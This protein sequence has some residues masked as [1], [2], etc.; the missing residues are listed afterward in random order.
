MPFTLSHAAAALPFRRF[1]PVWPALV[2]GTM[3]P[4]FEYFL[5]LSDEGRTGHHFPGLVIITLP[6]AILVFC[7][8][9]CYVRKPIVE[10]LPLALQRR[11]QNHLKSRSVTGWKSFA[12]VMAWILCGIATHLAWDWCTHPHTWIWEHWGWLRQKV[13]VPFHPPVMMNKLVQY[14]S[15]LFGLTVLTIWFVVWYYRAVPAKQVLTKQL[16][17]SRKVIIV[18]IMTTVVVIAGYPLA[19]Q[20]VSE[21]DPAMNPINVAAT[22]VEAVILL[23][24]LQILLYGIVR[25]YATRSQ[26]TAFS[27]ADVDHTREPLRR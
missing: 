11:L 9:E 3:A 26:R 8:F 5:R 20:R 4:D 16:T 15:S 25:T 27:P 10:L 7:L 1:K 18:G 22:F 21:L 12:V 14:A 24:S 17:P 19:I 6:L 23:F 13:A 2:I